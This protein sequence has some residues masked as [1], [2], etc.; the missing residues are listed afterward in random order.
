MQ[1]SLMT[2]CDIRANVERTFWINVKHA[3]FLNIATPFNNDCVVVAANS[4]TRPNADVIAEGDVADDH[5]IFEYIG[6]GTNL[7]AATVKFVDWQFFL[8]VFLQ[9]LEP[10]GALVHCRPVL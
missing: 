3:A 4:D 9:K 5:S 7:W 2:Y 6:T 1:H 10:L 8:D